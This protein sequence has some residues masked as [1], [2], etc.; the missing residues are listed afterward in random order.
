MNQN[1]IYQI[2]QWFQ[3]SLLNEK[4]LYSTFNKIYLKELSEAARECSEDCS[5]FTDHV[6]SSP[7]P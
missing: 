4:L 6:Q 2:N 7:I 5:G 1:I 3:F